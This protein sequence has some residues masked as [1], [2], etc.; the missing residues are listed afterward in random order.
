MSER[1]VVVTGAYGFLGRHVARALAARGCTVLG[2]GHGSWARQEWKAWGLADWRTCDV[3]LEALETYAREPAAIVHCAGSASVAFSMAH[4]LLDYRRTVETT[5]AVLEFV[6]TRAMGAAVMLPSSGSVYGSSTA[7]AIPE[8]APLAP[9]SVYAV[10]K[11]LAE[12][13]CVAAGRFFGLRTAVVRFFSVHGPGLRKQLL[14]DACGKLSRGDVRFA[15]TGEET[16]DWLHVED[17]ASLAAIAVDHAVPECP[18][19]NG[20]SGVSVTVREIVSGVASAL[21]LDLAPVFSGV[22]RQGDPFRF[23]ADNARARSWGWV[24]R[25]GWRDGVRAYCEWFARGAP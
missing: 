14:W 19:V 1:L 10:H 25:I 21:T 16:R 13:L 4:P 7:A 22:A 15:G 17:A 8:S 11:L 24:P 2:L 5:A 12:Q 9:Q 20:G 3:T 18:I 6:R 23:V